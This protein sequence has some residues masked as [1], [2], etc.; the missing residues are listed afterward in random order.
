MRPF[1]LCLLVP[2]VAALSGCGDDSPST[3]P[4]ALSEVRSSHARITTAPSSEDL[5]AVIRANTTFALDLHRAA[6]PA[7]R[8]AVLSP[9]SVS[10]ALAM[11]WVGA[12]NATETRMRAAMRLPALDQAR[13]HLAFNAIDRALV[14]QTSHAVTM[15]SPRP[16]RLQLANALWAQRGY[17][18]Q[19]PF[20]DTLAEQYGAGVHV[21]DFSTA[22]DP[23]RI[24][25][26]GWV[27]DHTAGRIPDL[28]AQGTITNDTVFV[29][30]NAV[31]FIA[32]WR[33]LFDPART[34]HAEFHVSATTTVHAQ[35]MNMQ[36]RL[37]YA[38]G[39]GW[40]AVSLGYQGSDLSMLVVVPDAGHIADFERD[41]TA[42]RLD[43]IAAAVTDHIVTLA[44]PKFSFRTQLSLS[45]ALAGMGM[46]EEFRSGA[47]DFSGIDG[48][49]RISLKDVI[50]EGFIAVDENGTEAA[51]ATA[52]IGEVVS[53]PP[54]AA[55]TVDRP[56]VFAIRS[57]NGT[58]L[59]LG[60]VVDP[61]AS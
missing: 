37:P 24:A 43:M 15:E 51:A 31:H 29:L 32:G 21:T 17:S 61:T 13:V 12:R 49:R 22:P 54:P 34:A 52:V 11:T 46:A 45:T 38:E 28:L 19:T 55:L 27:S 35:T 6:A 36:A 59:F 10:T 7:G 2:L 56:F 47:A 18:F 25:I 40:K 30:T 60:R 48:T 20:L 26:N 3:S 23:S 16:A 4:G 14:E 1:R 58:V 50:H 33:R 41:L 42:E 57:A 53:L 9:H 39:E 8:N 5:S 44:M